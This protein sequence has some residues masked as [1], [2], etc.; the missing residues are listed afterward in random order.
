MAKQELVLNIVPINFLQSEIEVHIAPWVEGE[1]FRRVSFTEDASFGELIK[2][3]VVPF[4]GSRA[5]IISKENHF[6]AIKD[7]IKKTIYSKMKERG[8]LVSFDFVGDIVCFEK[9]ATSRTQGTSLYKRIVLR[10]LPPKEQFASQRK[11]WSLL[12]KYD[13]ETEIYTTTQA[14][15]K[16]DA[17]SLNYVVIGNEV[18]RYK[19]LSDTDK[20]SGNFHPVLNRQIATSKGLTPNYRREANKYLKHFNETSQF[21]EKY[22][23]EKV[24][25]FFSILKGGFQLVGESNISSPESDLNLLRFGEEKTHFNPYSGLKEHGPNK[26]SETQ[27]LKFI[28]VFHS[29]DRDYANKLYS[30]LTKGFKGFPGLQQFVGI[31]LKLDKDKSV[32]F[33][34]PENPVAEIKNKLGA[35]AF[36]E[37][38]HYFAFYI[39]RIRKDEVNQTKHDF[40]YQIKKLLLEKNI[41]SQAIYRDN[42]TNNNF[43][44]Y[45]PNIS[46]AIL[47]KLGG[48]PWRLSRPIRHDLVVGIGA[49]RTA[50][51]IYLGTA[52][53][54]KNDGTFCNF[55]AQKVEGTSKLASFIKDALNAASSSEVDLKRL[56]VHFYKEMSEEEEKEI[57]R[58]LATQG[59]N[60]PY[61]VLSITT[62]SDYIPYDLSFNGTMPVSGTC[63]KL[64]NGHYVL[65]NNTRYSNSVGAKIDDFPLPISIKISKTNDD[66]ISEEDE[67]LLIDQVYQFSRMYWRSIKQK[68]VPV[69]VLYSK[70]FA[71]FSSHAE[72]LER[73]NNDTVKRSLWFL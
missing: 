44:Y 71:E 14:S 55:D 25:S 1:R 16:L 39:S 35:L 47:A 5:V 49:F 53:A 54:F 73:L 17:S 43:N 36:D 46:I 50:E 63:I 64:R 58:A 29:E 69:T 6:K 30:Y 48:V 38:S 4:D 52:A 21:Y 62:D 13:G 57:V 32:T 7:V 22:L 65:C 34:D 20:Q 37:A 40:Y 8:F 23:S 2:M 3:D 42:I 18:K 31:P 11:G 41:G 56:V 9:Q 45:L 61:V 67:R 60:L 27:N 72:G 24:F 66:R 51:N 12:L 59:I 28:F 33:T 15:L 70:K 10:V 26:L 68:G 19:W